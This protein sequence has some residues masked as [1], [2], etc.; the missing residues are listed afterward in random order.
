MT[1][2]IN[3]IGQHLAEQGS[4]KVAIYLPNSIELLV[5]LFACSFYPNLTTVLIPFPA[6]DDELISM[7][8]R[9]AVDTVITASG[10]FPFDSVV[11]A[12]PSL[13][14]LIWVVD[15]GSSHLDW[16]EIPQ[17]M[18]GSVNVST[19]KD[20]I[21]DAPAS[22]GAELPEADP[23]M[24][25]SD[26]VVFWQAKPGEMEEMVRFTQGN[27]VAGVA[28]QIHALPSRDRLNPS[29]LFLPANSLVNSHTLTLTLA[30]L[31]SNASVALNSVAG[32]SLDLEV[33]TQ[34][35]APTVVAASP[36][37]LLRTHEESAGKL[38]SV[39]ARA[40][41]A[42]STRTLTQ[43]GIFSPG[44][45]L[46]PFSSGARPSIGT[47]PGKLRLL[48][49]A[50]RAGADEPHLSS[51]VLSDLRIVTGARVVY[52]L[53]ASKVAGAVSQTAM[54]DYRLDDG[55]KGHFGAPLTS[56]E[57]YLKDKG[58]LRTTDDK[59]EGEVSLY[60]SLFSW[61]FFVFFFGARLLGGC[62]RTPASPLEGGG[63]G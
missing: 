12:Y 5:A 4:I 39:L 21:Q 40:A 54:F 47:T 42:L 2:Q 24:A 1:R 14:Q 27:L 15:Q 10:S 53:G 63:R 57:V 18:G 9:S 48:Y 34:G 38:T 28:G 22:A 7:I 44:N 61:C 41:H 13:R 37:T 30:A 46:S 59:V 16:N 35:I 25:P 55:G 49:V 43:D 45:V 31:Y 6:G 33:A 29:D 11:G 32:Q 8:R 62:H 52:A 26:V 51:K 3:L 23:S 58:S 19:W 17:G 56:V 20:I 36:K 60:V 50:E